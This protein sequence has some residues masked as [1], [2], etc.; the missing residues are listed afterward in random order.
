M[1]NVTVR[2]NGFILFTREVSNMISAYWA[3]E[4]IKVEIEAQY[5]MEILMYEAKILA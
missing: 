3:I 4:I 1:Y 2:L 5:R